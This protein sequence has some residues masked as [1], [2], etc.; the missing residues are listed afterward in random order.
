MAGS[1]RTGGIRLKDEQDEAE[2]GTGTSLPETLSGL[3]RREFLRLNLV[4]LALATAPACTG[5][6]LPPDS[7]RIIRLLRADDLLALQVELINLE[8]VDRRNRPAALRRAESGTNAFLVVSF[9]GQHIAERAFNEA[10]DS[11]PTSPAKAGIARP[12]QL[13]FRLPPSDDPIDLTLASLLDW[14]NW[15]LHVPD[16][17]S[18]LTGRA[19]QRATRIELPTGLVLAPGSRVAW[20]HP[21]NPVRHNGRVELWHTRL[22]GADPASPARVHIQ[23]P[24][25]LPKICFPTALEQDDRERLVGKKAE[26]HTLILS[27][28]GGWLDIRGHWE[29]AAGPDITRWEH[30]AT[31]GQDQKVVL[32]YNDGFL[33]PFGHSATIVSVTERRLEPNL[34]NDA[35]WRPQM[36]LLRKR[37]FIVVKMPTINYDHGDMAFQAITIESMVTP[38][39]H[40]D[41]KFADAFWIETA[42]G[43]P[44]PF[45]FSA[46]DWDCSEL[47]F[48]GAAVFVQN[49]PK[50]TS[51]AAELYA[52]KGYRQHRQVALRGQAAAVARY[53]PAAPTDEALHCDAGKEERSARNTTLHLL[54]LEL[55]GSPK[56]D[57]VPPFTCRTEAMEVRLPALEPYLDDA[58]NR[59]WFSLRDPDEPGNKGEVFAVALPERSP[60]IPMYFDKQA[61]LSGGLAAPS[62]DVDGLSRIYGPV[63]QAERVAAGEKIGPT[64]YFADAQANLLGRFSLI[65]LI[66]AGSAGK[67]LA[68]PKIEFILS[69]K[70]PSEKPK[71]NPEQDPAEETKKRNDNEPAYW[72]AGTGLSWK[73]PLDTAQDKTSLVA[74]EAI[75]EDGKSTCALEIDVKATRRIGGRTG[76][77]AQ[78]PAEG[79]DQEAKP[80][81]GA[82]NSGVN[83]SASGKLKNFALALN[84]SRTDKL[85]I[86]FDHLSVKLGPPKKPQRKNDN[87]DADKDSRS[88]RDEKNDKARFEPEIEF[89]LARVEASG[90]LAF[91]EKV[92]EAVTQLPL[93]SLPAGEEPSGA[94]PAKLPNKG[95]ADLSMTLGPFEAPKFKLLQFE[96][97]R[98][99]ATLGIGLN[100]LPRPAKDGGEPRVPDHV[101]SIRVASADKPLTL[102][103]A[104]WGG[105]A[106]LGLNFT[107]KQLTAFQY[108]MGVIY[109]VEFDLALTKAA[110]EGSLA[111]MFTYTAKGPPYQIDLILTLSGQAKLWFIDIYILLVTVGSWDHVWSFDALLTVRVQIGFFTV[112]ASYGLHYTIGD[113]RKQVARSPT[114]VEQDEGRLSEREW[115][116]YRRAFATGGVA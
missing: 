60:P 37:D 45:Q 100:F 65:P 66:A 20:R 91:I 97:S 32:E 113:Q 112:T 109:K 107:T 33:Y 93:P 46:N 64:D 58:I 18:A 86:R 53:K 3:S 29:R 56:P 106:H 73:I 54:L 14:Q 110:C 87:K 90:A 61:D 62:F 78:K 76:S 35:P 27:P 41:D 81:D 26:A 8:I 102:L 36:A 89:K 17:V 51:A 71:P 104:P 28:M 68:I 31:A 38:A 82:G 7:R 49:E 25:Y 114:G 5:P 22:L 24:G 69:R 52:N 10:D 108:S 30:R 80:Y 40:I 94:Y 70:Q 67:S 4:L 63:G 43:K 50:L 84:L 11:P 23:P 15:E 99:S 79:T 13:V 115:L 55:T 85:S 105:I 72:E 111:A 47:N 1:W 83:L 19:G 6:G 98:V 96:V 77:K 88:D 92:I 116:A 34:E 95:D 42:P 59:G 44:F 16:E 48:E 57:S 75:H 12:S 9:P 21:V 101:F 39:L 103:A 2:E 74:F